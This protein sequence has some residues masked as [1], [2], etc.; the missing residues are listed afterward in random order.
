MVNIA[1]A[2]FGVL[3]GAVFG[4]LVYRANSPDWDAILKYVDELEDRLNNLEDDGK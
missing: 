4:C 2:V 3:L 1:L